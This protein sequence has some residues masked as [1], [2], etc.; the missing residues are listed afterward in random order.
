MENHSARIACCEKGLINANSFIDPSSESSSRVIMACTSVAIGNSSATSMTKDIIFKEYNGIRRS[1]S[2]KDIRERT[3]IKRSYSDNHICY[4][5]NKIHATSTQPKPKNNNNNNNSMGMR[6]FPLKF[7]GSFLPHPIRSFLFDMEETSKD[8]SSEEEVTRRAN[9]IE[10][11]LEIRRHWRTKQKKGVENDIYAHHDETGERF[12]GEE[13]GGCEVDYYDSE[14]EG[15]FSF[16]TESFARF[17]V[18]VPLSDTKVFSQLA[19]LSN[20]AYVIPEIKAEELERCCGLKFVTSS[21]L[22]KANGAAIN[23]KEKQDQHSTCISDEAL[24]VAGVGS[25]EALQLE[26]TQQIPTTVAYEIAATAASYMHSRAKNPSSHPLEPQ[27]KGEGTS[28]AYNPEVAAYVA[29]STMTAVVAAEEVQKQET[30]KGLQSLH[31]SPCEWFVCDDIH[32]STRYFIIQGSDSLA[33]W[34]ANLFFEPTK[35]EGSDVLVHRGIYEA[36]KGI[37]KQFI[38]EIIEH[39][40]KYG[41]QAKF[42]FT[43]HSLGGS[44]SLLVHLMLL[45][46]EIVKPCMLQPVVTFGSPFVFC[47]GHKILI[48]LGLDE[49]DIRCIIMHRDIVPRAFS[50]N[51]PNHVAAVLKRLSGSF[52]SHSCLNKSKLLYSPLGKIFI[53]Q[54]EEM[55]SPPHPM[56]PEGSALYTLDS[57]QNG[58]S[59]GLLRAFLNCPH[60]LETLSDPTAYGSEG[61]ILRDHDSSFYLKALN[62]VLDQHTKM[63]TGKVRKQRKLL[64]PLLTSPSPELW[65][66]DGNLDNKNSLVSNEI[67]TGV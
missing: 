3:C 42:Q 21:L 18:K 22:K 64:L 45:K 10:R 2:S 16:D 4:S 57:T 40:K 12:C 35:F 44:L 37:Y 23:M 5:A 41:T 6:I 62:G 7:S 31:S 38:P 56:L 67:M 27:E 1:H 49:D 65:R 25:G 61:T 8:L 29:A 32:S 26:R 34:Q 33:S 55:S 63:H 9:W 30:A 17:L 28:R 15:E 43:G 24:N 11:L 19:F 52:R 36:A 54:P 48:E 14:D 66:H 53:L 39:L 59:I 20:M 58:Y 50:C 60:P 46:N 13:D 51:Y 47:G